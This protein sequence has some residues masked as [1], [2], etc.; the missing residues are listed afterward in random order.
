MDLDQVLHQRKHVLD[1]LFRLDAP[2]RECGIVRHIEKTGV[3]T[4]LGDLAKDRQAAK[5]GIEHEYAR[6][7]H[8]AFSHEPAGD[9]QT[10]IIV[11]AIGQ[12]RRRR[13]ER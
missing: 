8:V 7:V 13:Y 9:K 10:H 3:R 12:K 5:T 4:G 11:A 6:G 1:E 2:V